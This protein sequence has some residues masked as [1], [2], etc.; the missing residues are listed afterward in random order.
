MRTRLRASSLEL[1]SQQIDDIEREFADLE[2][3]W[4]AEKAS[5]QGAASIK[6]EIE[7]ARWIS[8]RRAGPAT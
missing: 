8:R 5:L 2:E 3:I 7:Q 1:L 6:G 4:K